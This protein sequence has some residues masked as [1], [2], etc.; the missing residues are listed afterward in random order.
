MGDPDG[1]EAALAVWREGY[2]VG[3]AQDL[4]LEDVL[5]VPAES[6]SSDLPTIGSAPTRPWR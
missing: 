5:G 2:D 4:E 3:M 1:R 6:S